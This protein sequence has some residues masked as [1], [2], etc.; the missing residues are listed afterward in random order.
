M[1]YARGIVVG[2]STSVIV[3]LLAFLVFFGAFLASSL[4]FPDDGED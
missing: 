4:W 3:M 1:G 2:F